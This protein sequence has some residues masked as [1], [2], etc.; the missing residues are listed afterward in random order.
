[1]ILMRQ[2]YVFFGI[3]KYLEKKQFSRI[4]LYRA[5]YN[6]VVKFSQIA[7]LPPDFRHRQARYFPISKGN[8]AAFLC[9]KLFSF[10]G[11]FWC[12]RPDDRQCSGVMW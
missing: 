1:M 3:I 10:S 12:G 4:F 9:K 11:Y 7:P 5:Q 6:F 2:R 8:D